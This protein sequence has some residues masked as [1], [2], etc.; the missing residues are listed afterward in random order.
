MKKEGYFYLCIKGNTKTSFCHLHFEPCN[1]TEVV[2]VVVKFTSNQLLFL[3]NL[4]WFYSSTILLDISIILSHFYEFL[5]A[6]VELDSDDI[7]FPL[8]DDYFY[9]GDLFGWV[10]RVIVFKLICSCFALLIIW[11]G[12]TNRPIVNPLNLSDS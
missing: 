3:R 4:K 7:V 12:Q 5:F 2:I 8:L 11:K 1:T 6:R 10:K 9:L